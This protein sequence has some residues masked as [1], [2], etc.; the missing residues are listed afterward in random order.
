MAHTCDACGETFQTLTKLRLHDCPGP[1]L[2]ALDHVK[3]IVEEI[4]EIA[5]GD[6]LATFPDESVPVETVEGLAKA[7]KIQTALP[8]MSGS[9]GTGLTERIALQADTGGAV[10]EYF[11]HRGWIA[12]RTVGGEGK[13]EDQLNEEL[14]DQVQDWQSVVTD[15]ALGH[16]SGDIDAKKELRRELGL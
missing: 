11:P 2:D 9:P 10:I 14:M 12:V 8:L 15:L 6:V 5:Q 3:K 13:T 16:A 7:E 1:A 4:G